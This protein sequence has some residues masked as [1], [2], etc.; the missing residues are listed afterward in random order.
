MP[1]VCR[2]R[3]NVHILGQEYKWMPSYNVLKYLKG[4][5]QT[6]KLASKICPVTFT[7]MST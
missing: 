1:Y 3:A 5:N 4:I 7:G 6:N 2:L